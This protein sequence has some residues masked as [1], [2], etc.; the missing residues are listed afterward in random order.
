[1]IALLAM[2]GIAFCI[3]GIV[4]FTIALGPLCWAPWLIIYLSLKHL[5]CLPSQIRARRAEILEAA[6]EAELEA[7]TR[8]NS[9]Y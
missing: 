9:L 8:W 5:E 7:L 6:I 1:M 3:I 2:A 4:G